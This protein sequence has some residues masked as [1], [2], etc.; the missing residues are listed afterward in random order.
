MGTMIELLKSYRAAGLSIMPLRGDK[1]PAVKEWNPLRERFASDEELTRWQHGKRFALIC[2]KGSG[3]VEVI[4]IDVKYDETGTLLARLSDIFLDEYPALWMRLVVQSTPSGG[5]HLIFRCNNYGSNNSSLARTHDRSHAIIETRGDGG[6]IAV[7]PTD[8]YSIDRGSLLDIPV[9]SDDER[10][11]I[12][13]LC[14]SFDLAP[15]VQTV[16][17]VG[18]P[19]YNGVKRPGD[20]FTERGDVLPVLQRHGWMP[21]YTRRDG[22]IMIRRPGK[23]KGQGHSATLHATGHNKLYVFSS[24]AAPFEPQRVYDAFA[25]LAILDY[26]GDFA[27]AAR[28]LAKEGFGAKLQEATEDAEVSNTLRGRVTQY[29]DNSYAFRY[30]E[31]TDKT[32]F[33][34][35]QNDWNELD[36]RTLNSIYLELEG[37]HIK[38]S[39][40]KLDLIIHSNY[41]PVYNPFNEWIA[42]LPP[43]NNCDNI[44]ELARTVHV[45]GDHSVFEQYLTKWMVAHMAQL[46]AGKPNHTA[47]VFKGSQ[48]VGKTTWLNRLCPPELIS[49]RFEGDIS[50]ENKDHEFLAASKFLINLDELENMQRQSIGHLKSLFTKEYIS[51]RRPYAR[52]DKQYPRRA[53]FV[54]SVNKD[55]FLTD[56]TGNRRFLVVEVTDIEHQHMININQC[57]AEALYLYKSGYQYWFDKTEIASINDRNE[58]HRVRS[59]AEELVT[60]YCHPPIETNPD[61]FEVND[62]FMTA[63]DVARAIQEAYK[64]NVNINSYF[65][66]DIG[67]A[68]TKCGFRKVAKK[69]AGL[70]QRGYAVR[71]VVDK[72]ILSTEQF[73]DKF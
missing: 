8:G 4:D 28:A 71:V 31:I 53:S 32:E 5:K 36:D 70:S 59:L 11:A 66:A 63:S 57:W 29:L 21:E 20:D 18:Q 14:A 42:S 67:R 35:V 39:V 10:N 2:G 30:N 22:A 52:S 13:E 54:G 45:T 15:T 62:G 50:P 49:Y 58:E 51:Q 16:P 56:D 7:A 64:V 37:E 68:L 27:A 65:I 55:R 33:S 43:H 25:V 40:E 19:K 60:Q 48:G 24:S 26:G 61:E 12:M 46:L 38:C 34:A 9:I 44:G 47:I 1:K 6:Y 23:T 41:T 69:I 72:S 17:F 3:G 73:E